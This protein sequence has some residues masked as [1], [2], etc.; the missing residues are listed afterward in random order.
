[1]MALATRLHEEAQAQKRQRRCITIGQLSTPFTAFRGMWNQAFVT[2][3]DMGQGTNWCIFDPQ[4]T[5]ISWWD[6]F[7]IIGVIY[8]TAYTPLIT[9][10]RQ[11]QWSHHEAADTTLVP[12]AAV[13]TRASAAASSVEVETTAAGDGKRCTSTASAISGEPTAALDEW[14]EP[15]HRCSQEEASAVSKDGSESCC[16]ARCR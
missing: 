5:F 11:A 3:L 7:L 9:V 8:S 2:S 10:F 16:C 14:C 12:T 15:S 4:S 13:P 1:M 6:S